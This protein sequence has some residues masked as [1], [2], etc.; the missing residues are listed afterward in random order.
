MTTAAR[1]PGGGLRRAAV[2]LGLLCSLV[3][4]GALSGAVNRS[5]M[6]IAAASEGMAVSGNLLLRDGEPFLPRGFNMI[7][8]LTPAWCTNLAGVDART[9]FT[10]EEMD[11]AHAWQANT[12]RFQVSQRGLADPTRSQ[13]ERDAYLARVIQ[14]VTLARDNGFVVIVSMQDQSI[15]CGDVHPMP[16]AETVAAWSAVAPPF[17]GDA[18]V[19]FEL[20]NEPRNNADQAG[21]KQWLEGGSVPNANLGDPAVGHQ[22]LV[23]HLR[24]M[25]S[26]NVLIA[27]AAR[28][29]GQTVGMPRLEDPADRM[30]Y[31]IHP[32]AFGP[33]LSWW[34]QQYGPPAAE[35]P[36]LATEWNYLADGCGGAKE[37]LAPDLLG[38]LQDHGIGVFGHAFDHPGHTIADWTWAPTGCGTGTGGSGRLLKDFFAGQAVADLVPP[39]V[40][41]GL[42]AADVAFDHVTLTWEPATDDGGVAGYQVLRGG[43]LVG[44][45]TDPTWTDTAVQPQTGYSYEVRAV[46]RSGNLSGTS[47]A[48]PVTT[49]ARPDTT[50]PT[51]PPGLAVRIVSPTEVQLRWQ[52]STD[53]VGVV[54]YAVSRDNG[55][56]VSVSGLTWSDTA[57]T[58]GLHN[59][60]VT[61]LDAVGHSSPP[62]QISVTVPAAAP[63]GLTGTYF[64]TAT[65][66]TQRLVRTDT[67]V[68]FA[69]GTGRPAPNVGP[70]TFS[71]R[72]TGRL[73]PVAA[74]SYTFSVQSEDAA[75]L[76]IDG[77]LVVDDWTTHALHERSG[78][79]TL[80]A[81]QAHDLRLDYIERT[82]KAT[83]RLMWAGPSVTKQ[84]IPST[85]LL[86]R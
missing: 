25:G 2:C 65:F 1:R 12:L 6:P 20:F 45:P 21:W 42:A 74:G 24:T 22:D 46:D 26:T 76:W 16:S 57:A 75:R 13:D 64:D 49:P 70:D 35:V 31:A 79:I 44:Q 50:A 51:S 58:A 52:S 39:N 28:L 59:Y 71:V 19:M 78:T 9:H 23:D 15:G 82:G 34:E 30:A 86:A 41:A 60:A 77:R 33:G 69:W 83:I 43:V 67:W 29:G 3:A 56:P 81:N 14:G 66:T 11:A 53:D 55:A 32:Y 73:L 61:A 27:D 7:G 54:G 17:L 48:L 8:L 36:V 85:Q 38:Y 63:R 4:V 68:N 18:E 40:P 5:S 62:A 72:W 84:V 37:R 10:Q 80:T 47:A